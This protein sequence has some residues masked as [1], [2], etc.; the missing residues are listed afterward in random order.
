M[1]QRAVQAHEA[2]TIRFTMPG[3]A[4][5]YNQEGVFALTTDM[6]PLNLSGVFESLREQGLS[7]RLADDATAMLGEFIFA[8]QLGEHFAAN[9]K[10][11][12]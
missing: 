6:A 8:R 2:N 3:L 1:K 5:D 11:V 10:R 12:G 7:E 4:V 9:M